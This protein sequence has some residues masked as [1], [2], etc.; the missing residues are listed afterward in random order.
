MT[1]PTIKSFGKRVCF[2]FLILT[3]RHQYGGATDVYINPKGSDSTGNGSRISPW[4]TLRHACSNVSSKNL[5][6]IHLDPGIFVEKRITVPP[7]VSI[8]GAGK[9]LSI[10]KPDP[11]EYYHPANPGFGYEKFLINL[12]SSQ[13]TSGN[14]TIK[15]IAIDGADKKLH[16][17]IYVL[18]RSTI[19]IENVIVRYV[20]FCGV[21]FMGIKDSSIKGLQLKDCAWGSS[22]WCS[23][24]LQIA[25]SLNIDVAGFNIDES[26]GYGVK[27]LAQTQNTPF[28]NIRIHDGRISVSPEGA[29]NRGAAPNIAIEIWASSFPGTEIYNCYVDNH[30]S[31][32]NYPV[33]QRTTP[34]KIYN[35]VF[36]LLGARAKGNGYCIELSL[37]D[38]EIYNNWFNGGSTAIVNWGDRQFSNWNIHHNTFYSISSIYPTAII[39]SYK[40][41]LKDVALYNNTAEMTGTATVNFIEFN[42]GGLSDNIRIKNNL[43][44]NSNTSYAHYPNRF[45]SLEKGS[46]IKNLQVGNNLLYNLP[47]GNVP[48]AYTHNLSSNPKIHQTGRRPKPYY[49]PDAGSPLIDGGLNVGFS[50][51]GD[52]PDIGAYE[53]V[54]SQQ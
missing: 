18:N 6:T 31:L 35:N 5:T 25:N 14:Q 27:N 11:S 44:I 41:G 53:F 54:R 4:R 42:N 37:H 43:I 50:F 40:G 22:D 20:N 30:I 8:I 15:D 17:G 32:V 46:S 49:F 34:I 10:I 45:I 29:W 28:S 48:G 26:K 3:A 2:V 21:W 38:A 19:T 39:T 33:V 13:L 1:P 12:Q 16:G 47:I 9:D 7:G 51:K 24:A 52:A 23:G 36:D